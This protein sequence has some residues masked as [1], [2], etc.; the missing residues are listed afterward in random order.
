M[1]KG[2]STPCSAHSNAYSGGSWISGVLNRVPFKVNDLQ[3]IWSFGGYGL[4]HKL[5]MDQPYLLMG[6]S[7]NDEWDKLPDHRFD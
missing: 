1:P 5:D 3:P 4:P 2:K 7:T 6:L